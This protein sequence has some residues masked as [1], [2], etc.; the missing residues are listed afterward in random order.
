MAFVFRT[1]MSDI[2]WSS[3]KRGQNE[4]FHRVFRIQEEERI[5]LRFLWRDFLKSLS[6]CLRCSLLINTVLGSARAYGR[7]LNWVKFVPVE[8]D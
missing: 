4:S 2:A 8:E 5:V 1:L 6:L 7:I 3:G